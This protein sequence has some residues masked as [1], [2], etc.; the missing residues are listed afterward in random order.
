MDALLGP[1]SHY[2]YLA[3]PQ[4]ALRRLGQRRQAAAAAH[5]RRARPRP[6][7]GL[8]GAGSAARLPH[9]RARPAR[10]RRLAV[11]DR[12]QLR[13]GRLHARRRAAA[14]RAAA[15]VRSP[16]SATRSAARSRCSTPASTPTA[17]ARS[18]PSKASARRPS[19]CATQPPAH[20]RM[21]V[22]IGEMKALARRHPH[23]YATLD[24]AVA[25]MRD[26]NPHLTAEQARHLTVHGSYRD[27]DGTYL[28]KFDNY[29]RATSPYLF[30]MQRRARHLDA[31]H[32]PGAAAAR[33]RVVGLRSRRSTAAPRPSATTRSSTSKAPA[34]GCTT[35]SW[36]CS[37][38]SCATFLGVPA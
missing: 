14:Q 29:V 32:L 6:Q 4:A 37:C 30:N 3:A 10:P 9:H 15:S 20:E 16:S 22:W 2:F 33:H 24:E 18:S 34:T 21:Q 27:E 38:G 19:C 8:G 17:S 36:R 26:A 13:D 31:D 5:P 28:W 23:R 25:R 11:G 7:L 1:T 12:R 35:T